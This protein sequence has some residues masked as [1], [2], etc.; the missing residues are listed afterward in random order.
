VTH[1]G[2]LSGG[3][4]T[5]Y[6]DFAIFIQKEVQRGN[7]TQE[8]AILHLDSLFNDLE[9]IELDPNSTSKQWLG[10]SYRRWSHFNESPIENLLK[11]DK[12]LFVGV[13][14]KDEAVPVESSLLIPVE[15]IRHKKQNLT[16]KVYPDYD[17]S[18][19]LVPQSETED[20]EWHFMTVFD[21]FMQWV[22]RN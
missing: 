4:N 8:E 15:F 1:V 2:F 20:W 17:H 12:P 19:N 11:I 3:G 9:N 10:H 21:D 13:A 5:Q 18:F 7:I 6:Y 22:E 16:Y 14:G